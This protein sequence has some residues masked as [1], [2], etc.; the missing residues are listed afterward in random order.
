MTLPL[1][2]SVPHAGLEVPDYLRSQ[3]RLSHE[4]IVADGDEGAAEVYALADEVAAFVT[5]PIARAVLD[6]NRSSVDRR[7]DGVVKTHTC[8]DVPVWETPLEQESI[9]KLL[10]E[11]DRYHAE[12]SSRAGSVLMGVDC[13]TMAAVG[14]PVAPDPGAERPLVCLGDGDGACPPEWTQELHACFSRHFPGR[15][16]INEPFAGGFITRSHASEMPW[17]QVELSRTAEMS[18]QE[19]KRAVLAALTD[20]CRD[21]SQIRPGAGRR[22]R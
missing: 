10:V 19:K 15:V 2:L 8:W 3:C 13:H 20:W 7:K 22:P 5:T 18:N 11:H 6:M 12:L 21:H 17:I 4:E 16:T 14:P 9:E 1:L